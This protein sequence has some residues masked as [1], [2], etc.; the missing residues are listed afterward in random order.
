MV[1]WWWILPAVIGLAA[2]VTL[3]AGLGALFGGRP[4][5]GLLRTIGGAGVGAAAGFLAL[6]AA[7]PA[8]FRVIDGARPPAAVAAEVLAL[9]RAHLGI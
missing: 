8:R 7:H 4:V 9:A 1:W 2:V 6:A 3:F 5:S